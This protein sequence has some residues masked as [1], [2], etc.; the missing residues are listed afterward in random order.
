MH[1][2]D[3]QLGMT[4]AP[5]KKAQGIDGRWDRD[6]TVDLARLRQ[7]F[8]TDVLVSLIEEHEFEQLDIRRLPAAS[9]DAGILLDRFPIPD[10]GVP[11]SPAEFAA[12]VERT[13]RGLRAGK[14]VVVHCRGGLGRTGLLA[15]IC[16]RALGVE[17]ARAIEVVRAA[18]P[19]TIENATQ[20]DFVRNMTLPSAS[21]ITPG[22]VPTLSRFRGCLLGGALGDS[23]GEPVEF[24]ASAKEI[25]RRFGGTAPLK[26]GFA[27]G[28]FITDDTQM[29]LFAAEG[30]IRAGDARW[31]KDGA[32]MVREVQAAFLRWFSTQDGGD[33]VRRHRPA[34]WSPNGASIIDVRPARRA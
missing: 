30:I 34:G 13:V 5:G 28:P 32:V 7:A 18:R 12:L 26:L 14:T 21:T 11:A 23:L 19:G 15:A 10:G 8:A 6:L 4:F 27:H 31:D 1:G 33:P 17:A 29:T 9:E 25:A 24:I 16:L 20:E 22:G 3:G 2:L